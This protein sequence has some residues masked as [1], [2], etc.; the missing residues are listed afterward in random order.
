MA[1]KLIRPRILDGG[2]FYLGDNLYALNSLPSR[3]VNLAYIDPPYNTG[4][5]WDSVKEN[6]SWSDVWSWDDQI[7][8]DKAN[9]VSR[10]DFDEWFVDSHA[11][12][13]K[14]KQI[15]KDIEEEADGTGKLE[16]KSSAY[17]AFMIPRLCEIYR[18]LVNSGSLFLHVNDIESDHLRRVCDLIFGRKNFRSRLIWK[19][20]ETKM[21]STMFSRMHDEILFYTKNKADAI[22]SSRFYDYTE[23][24][25]AGYRFEDEHGRFHYQSTTSIRMAADRTYELRWKGF[26]WADLG[27]QWAIPTKSRIERYEW[28]NPPEEYEEWRKTDGLRHK[29]LDYLEEHKLIDWIDGKPLFRGY[30][31]AMQGVK[32]GSLVPDSIFSYRLPTRFRNEVGTAYRT[33]KPPSLIR[34]L[35]EATTEEEDIVLDPFGG[36]GMTSA[37]AHSLKR[38]WITMDRTEGVERIAPILADLLP[39]Y[40][41]E[42]KS[43]YGR[44]KIDSYGLEAG[45]NVRQMNIIRKVAESPHPDSGGDFISGYERR[46]DL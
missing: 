28:I 14:L 36:S 26:D 21:H 24:Q 30:E 38:K 22:W 5:T 7:H 43:K 16:S 13:L 19:S 18:V 40:W 23:E 39:A 12:T 11:L 32:I 1:L 17:V 9:V 4:K 25:L 2:H 8:A 44:D 29:C 33:M 35:I 41:D 27:Q 37:V 42:T 45:N 6:E 20:S 34:M 3:I 46:L 10:K 15:V 31:S